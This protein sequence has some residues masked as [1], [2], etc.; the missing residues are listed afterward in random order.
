MN[1]KRF[2]VIGGHPYEFANNKEIDCTIIGF[3]ELS[4]NES[5]YPNDELKGYLT[6][7]KVKYGKDACMQDL[8][9]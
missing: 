5:N 7:V 6:T 2:A 4:K 1:V 3:G 8:D 9:S